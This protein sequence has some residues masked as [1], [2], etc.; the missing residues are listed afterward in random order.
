MGPGSLLSFSTLVVYRLSFVVGGYYVADYWCQTGEGG[1]RGTQCGG[2]K[3][4]VR[5]EA[6]QCLECLCACRTPDHVDG[7]F[8]TG[9]DCVGVCAAWPPYPYWYCKK[10][11]CQWIDHSPPPPPPPP[12]QPGICSDTCFY[13]SDG[14][15]DDGGPGAAYSRCSLGSDCTD[16]GRRYLAGPPPP[17]RPP[18][19]HFVSARGY[20]KFLENIGI[21]RSTTYIWGTAKTDETTR[22][23]EWASEIT[24]AVHAGFS[25][26]LVGGVEVSGAQASAGAAGFASAVTTTDQEEHTVEYAVGTVWQFVYDVVDHCGATSVK[27]KMAVL[28]AN[29]EEPPCCLPGRFAINEQWHGPCLHSSPC[30]CSEE[31]CS[32]SSTTSYSPP[33]P[34]GSPPGAPHGNPSSSGSI[35]P[36]IGAA[37]GGIAVL[38][39]TTFICIAMRKRAHA[40][41]QKHTQ[42]AVAVQVVMGEPMQVDA[43]EVH[44]L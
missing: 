20:W 36:L 22:S 43:G 21:K 29:L 5:A 41:K 9:D 15:C 34:R 44:M 3:G 31:V 25:F 13:D 23:S 18:S 6:F 14:T 42:P 11:D 2:K 39:A 12:P 35:G 27:I 17:P 1:R 30:L 33:A 38:V 24:A 16:C 19:C 40:K 8:H 10:K 26:G 4:S 28:T 7:F 37:G 32:Q